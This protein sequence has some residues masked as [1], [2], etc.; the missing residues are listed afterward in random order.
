MAF[1]DVYRYNELIDGVIGG[2]FYKSLGMVIP[3]RS[4]NTEIRLETSSPNTEFGLYL[5]EAFSGTVRSDAQGNVV[6]S[7]HFDF[8]EYEIALLN[9]VTG[10]RLPSWVTVRDYAIW[11]VSYAEVFESID[12]NIQEAQDDLS[13]ET[14]TLNGI[15]DHFGKAIE[16][17]N[18]LGQGLDAYRNMIHELRLG[19]R[20]FGARFRGLETAVAAFT[21]VP[22]FG[23]T[24][25]MWGPN[26]WLNHSMSNNFRFLKRSHAISFAGAGIPGVQL[27]EAEP[28][29]ESWYFYTLDYDAGTNELTWNVAGT[30][31][32]AV[33]AADGVLFIPG[34]PS[35][36]IAHIL[37]FAGPFAITASVNDR[38]YLNVDDLGSIEISLTTGG[39]VLLATIITDINNA[40]V[41]DPRYGAGYA[42]FASSYNSKLLLESPLPAAGT[43]VVLEHG[44]RNAAPE[45]FGIR[46]RDLVYHRP[47]ADGIYIKNIE[48]V[49][50]LTGNAEIEYEYDGSVDPVTRRLRFRS[51]GAAWS[52]WLSITDPGDYSLTDGNS[53]ILTVGCLLDLMEVLSSPWPATTVYSFSIGYGRVHR[54]VGYQ[55][56]LRVVCDAASLPSINTSDTVNIVDDVTAGHLLHPDGWWLE[57]PVGAL[58][59]A[60]SASP[61][62]ITDKADPF[63][64]APAFMWLIAEFGTETQLEIRSHVLKHPMPRPGPRGSNYP[65][66]SSGMFYDYEGFEAKLSGWFLSSFAGAATVTPG[67]SFDGGSTWVDGAPVAVPEDA[68]AQHYEEFGYAEFETVIPPGVTDNGI[69]ARF[70]FD[71]ASGGMAFT[72]DGVNVGVNLISSTYLGNVTTPRSRHRQNFGELVWLWAPTPLTLT[73]KEYLG[74][75]HKRPSLRTPVAGVEITV[76]SGD[77]PAGVGRLEYEYNRVGDTR[78]L[79]W[80]SYQSS[81]GAWVS[82]LSDGSYTLLSADG[83]SITV[84]ATRAL[85]PILTGSPPAV[86]TYRDVT[87]TDQTVNQ[88]HVRRISA[89]QSSIDVLDV[90]EYDVS[91]EPTN[92]YGALTEADFSAAGLVNSDIEPA[93]PF[94]ESFVFPE[95]PPQEGEIL[96]FSPSGPNWVATLDYYSDEDQ[97]N[98]LLYED[99]LLVPNDLWSFSAANE[100][101]LTSFSAG[102]EYTVDYGLLYQVTTD[103]LDLSGITVSDYIWLADYMLWDRMDKVQDAYESAIPVYF[104]PNNGRAG[105]VGES[106]QNKATSSLVIQDGTSTI[107]VA[108]RYWRFVDAK[109]IE[110]DLAQLVRGAQYFLTHN[111]LR[112]YP[113]SR[114]TSVFEHRSGATE[115]ACLAASWST[116]ERNENVR[117]DHDFHQLRLSVTGIRDLRDFR[118]RSLVLKGLHAF[119]ANAWVPGLTGPA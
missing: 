112:V 108:Q 30:P 20:N 62:V 54:N 55:Q 87:I 102:A 31:G 19:Y 18:N 13:I 24:R 51:N 57:N 61:S 93:D 76:V 80:M 23:Y 2:D 16:T 73:E 81:F 69:L 48:G 28:D 114:L 67:F 25:R 33:P 110:L 15:E 70:V 98:T 113:E 47:V 49:P 115:L 22:P 100:I 94:K 21:Q 72:V 88:G 74:L 101:T 109:T 44:S 118:I 10:R 104:N 78:R 43:S 68:G 89:A 17:Y 58:V 7:R 5:N 34:P 86:T 84:Y 92:L 39:A 96:S 90:T 11:L 85:L 59:T 46:P 35:L 3:Y 65:Q 95:F 60:I 27:V 107:I 52:G 82:I 12:D 32:P 99:G 116:V 26:W 56:G 37:G 8:G 66:R 63:D 64:H 50:D 105:L 111:E 91:G 71:K 42:A 79:R 4:G 106:D 119:G 45:L 9:N 40:L 36:M 75:R 29:A 41:A 53:V 97:T 1:E 77:T 83:S 6:F 117:N 103:L 14:S 38:L